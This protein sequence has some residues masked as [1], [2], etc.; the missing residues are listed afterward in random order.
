M[1]KNDSTIAG[2]LLGGLIALPLVLLCVFAAGAGHGTYLPAKACFPI[3]MLS[4]HI[5]ESITVPFIVFALL[6]FPAYGIVLGYSRSHN[7]LAVCMKIIVI[8]HIVLA[9][10]A[11][12]IKS[13][14]FP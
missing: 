11:V 7:R 14:N 13:P 3:T 10:F 4:A 2:G 12:F 1:V 6:Q 8:L 5:F 9:L